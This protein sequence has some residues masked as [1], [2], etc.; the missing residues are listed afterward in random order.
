MIQDGV[1]QPA[2]RH[3]Y[4]RIRKHRHPLLRI[5]K[6]RHPL[7]KIHWKRRSSQSSASPKNI[8]TSPFVHPHQRL[9]IEE[10]TH[11]DDKLKWTA[12]TGRVLSQLGDRAHTGGYS[13]DAV[14]DENRSL[15]TMREG[16]QEGRERSISMSR[17]RCKSSHERG[18]SSGSMWVNTVA[19]GMASLI[20]RSIAS[21][22][23]CP[24]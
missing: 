17:S 19:E 16:D 22:K 6:H 18:S 2:H 11:P 9:E 7:L 1:R 8:P 3:Q 24:F 15:L 5:R 20:S 4:P 10:N 13:L 23:S 12:R 21:S 14:F